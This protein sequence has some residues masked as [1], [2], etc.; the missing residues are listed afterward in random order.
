MKN[1][2]FDYD[3]ALAILKGLKNVVD[4]SKVF[5]KTLRFDDPPESYFLKIS[6]F[7][8]VDEMFLVE[9]ENIIIKQMS[10]PNLLPTNS[11]LNTDNFSDAN[12]MR[13][14]LLIRAEFF[15]I[16]NPAPFLMFSMGRESSISEIVTGNKKMDNY[17]QERYHDSI[18]VENEGWEES[19]AD[20]YR[21]TALMINTNFSL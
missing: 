18:K 19:L 17:L 12:I 21:R 16:G 1:T 4:N 8:D 7:E 11:I 5:A 9:S 6:T 14:M 10:A 13:T 3:L 20:F 15:C 2:R